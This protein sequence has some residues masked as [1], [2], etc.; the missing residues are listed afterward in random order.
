METNH[1]TVRTEKPHE[2][3]VIHDMSAPMWM[4]VIASPAPI[5]TTFMY[6]FIA[7]RTPLSCSIEENKVGDAFLSVK[8]SQD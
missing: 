6:D 4:D 3:S 1:W 8:K 5:D 2:V 7:G